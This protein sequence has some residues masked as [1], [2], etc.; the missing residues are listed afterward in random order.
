M[1]IEH[2]PH[3]GMESECMPA[4]ID[5]VIGACDCMVQAWEQHVPGVVVSKLNG[6][7]MFGETE[8]GIR[9]LCNGNFALMRVNEPETACTHTHAKY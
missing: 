5:V 4:S 2:I 3:T 7:D 9:I 1:H 8:L 6:W